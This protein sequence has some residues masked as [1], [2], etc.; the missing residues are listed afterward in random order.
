MESEQFPSDSQDLFK[1][2][3]ITTLLASSLWIPTFTGTT[4]W[5]ASKGENRLA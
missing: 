5:R 3:V 4:D 2:E 1:V